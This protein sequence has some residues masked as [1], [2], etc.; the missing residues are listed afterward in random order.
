[1]DITNLSSMTSVDDQQILRSCHCGWSKETTFRGLRIHQ[2][3]NK[4][5]LISKIPDNECQGLNYFNQTELLKTYLILL[6]IYKLILLNVIE[7]FFF[8]M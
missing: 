2:G 1:M 5:V 3:K 7:G 4:C 8:F 6:V